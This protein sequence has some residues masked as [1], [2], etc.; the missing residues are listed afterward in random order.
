MQVI[1]LSVNPLK[2]VFSVSFGEFL[3]FT[4]HKKGINFNTTKATAI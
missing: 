4:V 1:K 3:G 2:Y